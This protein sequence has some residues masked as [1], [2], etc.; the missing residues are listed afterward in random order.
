ME[1]RETPSENLFSSLI[2][3][4]LSSV[5]FVQNYLQIDFDGY[6]LTTYTTPII[7][8]DALKIIVYEQI[9]YKNEL[10]NFIAKRV[11]KVEYKED[12]YVEIIFSDYT[13]SIKVILD[14]KID[15]IYYS[16]YEQ[17]WF[18]I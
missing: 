8:A 2:G 17:K 15:N 13:K 7:I 9:N 12:E 1:T 4:Q 16:D 10:C 6:K 14:K 11:S 5:C 18:V 3:E